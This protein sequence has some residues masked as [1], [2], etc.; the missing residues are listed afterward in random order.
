[1]AQAAIDQV[2]AVKASLELTI[3]ENAEVHE[4]FKDLLD[5]VAELDE[6]TPEA[7]RRK[8]KD[9]VA[10]GA[11]RFNGLDIRHF[12]QSQHAPL[13]PPLFLV[14]TKRR[15]KNTQTLVEEFARRGIFED[16]EPLRT[17]LELLSSHIVN[18]A[19]LASVREFKARADALR[20][21]SL[22]R[23][24]LDTKMRFIRKDAELRTDAEYLAA[25]ESVEEGEETFRQ[26]GED[27]EALTRD[28]ASGA[29]A[30]DEA[31]ARLDTMSLEAAKASAAA[32]AEAGPD[33]KPE[34]PA[35]ADTAGL[36]GAVAEVHEAASP[37]PAATAGPT[38]G[39]KAGPKADP[40]PASVPGAKGG[41]GAKAAGPRQRPS[42]PGRRA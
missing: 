23:S 38:A 39:P 21:S 6:E 22:F 37:E 7:R 2:A 34:V 35:D 31:Q 27:L 33:A 11:F 4:Y 18:E 17:E 41:P 36:A 30:L 25:R 16:A 26:R 20:E 28:I 12:T 5:K 3:A 15:L 9:L 32:A 42:G 40:K 10:M 1:M 29:L 14:R 24:Y 13:P 8:F 19:D